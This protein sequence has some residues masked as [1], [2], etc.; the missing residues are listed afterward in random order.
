MNDASLPSQLKSQWGWIALRGLVAVTFGVTAFVWPEPTLV[1]L[2]MVWGAYAFLDGVLALVTA[3]RV[4]EKL[5]PLWPLVIVGVLGI[6]AG[7]LSLVWPEIAAFS[8]LLLIAAWA[9]VMGAFQIVSAIRIRKFIEN[10][11]LLGSSGVFSMIF[12]A[13][14]VV[15][16]QLGALAIAWMIGAFALPFGFLLMA[17]AF[18]LRGDATRTEPRANNAPQAHSHIRR[19]AAEQRP[20]LTLLNR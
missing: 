20:P 13:V 5:R 4:R 16:P 11:W 12:G 9:L 17:L 3:F 18:R 1:T 7:I 15:D 10:E 6:V 19:P 2:T 14:M 8:L